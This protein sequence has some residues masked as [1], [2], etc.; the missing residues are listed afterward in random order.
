MRSLC[1]VPCAGEEGTVKKTLFFFFFL[2]LMHIRFRFSQTCQANTTSDFFF[3]ETRKVIEARENGGWATGGMGWLRLH[4]AVATVRRRRGMEKRSHIHP[5]DDG[6]I[7][8]CHEWN[9]VWSIRLARREEK[10]TKTGHRQCKLRRQRNTNCR[11]HDAK[12]DVAQKD[13]STGTRALQR[14]K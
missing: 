12:C 13:P 5:E 11:C 6:N 9:Q 7:P 8:T 2:S 4:Y 3:P 10:K 1:V 14:F